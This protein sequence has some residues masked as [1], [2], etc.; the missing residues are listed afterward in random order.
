MSKSKPTRRWW[1]I[2]ISHRAVTSMARAT[3]I[4]CF[5]F[6]FS[7]R[8]V[9]A[10]SWRGKPYQVFVLEAEWHSHMRD[11][12]QTAGS[13]ENMNVCW[14]FVNRTLPVEVLMD[15]KH[16]TLTTNRRRKF[17]AWN[18]NSWI[19]FAS[20]RHNSIFFVKL[21]NLSLQHERFQLKWGK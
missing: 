4:R 18:W 13:H 16:E 1:K 9:V 21:V 5:P 20:I 15:V 7:F 14:P 11:E 3:L 17:S 10:Q 6:F 19:V 12:L 2:E 8:S